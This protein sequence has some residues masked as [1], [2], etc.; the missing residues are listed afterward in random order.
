[1]QFSTSE[2]PFPDEEGSHEG[3]QN[4]HV[5]NPSSDGPNQAVIVSVFGKIKS[6]LDGEASSPNPSC[7]GWLKQGP[8][9]IQALLTGNDPAR[10][11]NN[12]GHG[13]FNIATIAAFHYG[14]NPD[15]SSVGVPSNFSITVNDN[16]AF[17]N[18]TDQKGHS[19]II[20]KRSYP[21]NTLKAQATILIHELGHLLSDAGL[22]ASGFQ[23]DFGIPKAGKANDALVDQNCRPL[24]E[25]LQ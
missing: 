11:T 21:G 25:G 22:G 4:L 24:I 18:A 5:T 10:P 12:F 1:M 16:G 14:T 20:G 6:A 8:T 17:F 15:R 19:F 7:S 2:W 9:T 23:H 13:I 3:I